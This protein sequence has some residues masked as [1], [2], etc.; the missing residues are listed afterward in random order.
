M[1]PAAKEGLPAVVGELVAK[2]R[3]QACEVDRIANES[4]PGTVKHETARIAA[5]VNR[6]RADELEESLSALTAEAGKGEESELRWVAGGQIFGRPTA[7][8]ALEY[9]NANWVEGDEKDTRIPQMNNIRLALS[10][11]TP[12]GEW[13]AKAFR[14][15]YGVARLRRERAR[16][17]IP[18]TQAE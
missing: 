1:T 4:L 7:V 14:D 9:A 6:K 12:A 2:W 18:A 13:V 8:D 17:A 5:R 15:D 10:T 11:A 16:C 3:E